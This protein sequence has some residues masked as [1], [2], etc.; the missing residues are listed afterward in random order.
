MM[1]MIEIQASKQ[2]QMWG[3]RLK[4]SSFWDVD[5][6]REPLAQVLWTKGDWVEVGI[7]DWLV[8]CSWSLCPTCAFLLC[9]NLIYLSL[10][11]HFPF[12]SLLHLTMTRHHQHRFVILSWVVRFWIAWK[13]DCLLIYFSQIYSLRCSS[14]LKQNRD[15]FVKGLVPFTQLVKVRRVTSFWHFQTSDFH[16]TFTR[17]SLALKMSRKLLSDP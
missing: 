4:A 1:S 15:G 5:I 9:R 7:T 12:Q 16:E 2:I 6:E 13:R 10:S 11:L 3:M 14:K 17:S 8:W